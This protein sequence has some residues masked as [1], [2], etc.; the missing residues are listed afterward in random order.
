[1][2]SCCVV[3]LL[4]SGASGETSGC[5]TEPGG[6][7][8][9]HADVPL[10]DVASLLQ[11]V[12][13]PPQHASAAATLT[14]AAT[15]TRRCEYGAD[16]GAGDC[17]LGV[18]S[19]WTACSKPC[20][21]GTRS[22]SRT[23]LPADHDG[24]CGCLRE[25]ETCNVDPCPDVCVVGLWSEWT[26][27]SKTCGSGTRS[28]SREVLSV[29]EQAGECP[30]LDASETCSSNKC[31]EIIEE[32]F[33]VC[34]KVKDVSDK[35]KKLEGV[36]VTI[37]TL[38]PVKTDGNGKFCFRLSP[39]VVKL[40]AELQGYVTEEDVPREVVP[41][42]N[43]IDDIQMSTLL[44]EDQ[45]RIVLKWKGKPEDLDSWTQFGRGK[46]Q[47]KYK[48]RVEEKDCTLWW[49][50]QHIMKRGLESKHN[51]KHNGLVDEPLKCGSNGVTA[52]LD[53]DNEDITKYD[54]AE[55]TTLGG[56]DATTC[57]EDCKIHFCVYQYV[58]RENNG[59]NLLS[60]A[61]VE[62]YNGVS[63]KSKKVHTFEIEKQ[64]KGDG[65][66]TGRAWF[67]FS[68]DAKTKKVTPC[69]DAS[70]ECAKMECGQNNKR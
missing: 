66:V 47:L 22:R 14:Q 67:V 31:P 30:C 52:H 62:I 32:L 1:M 45:W 58:P 50:Y 70:S 21:S 26:A 38:D 44:G 20:G 25:A 63:H 51:G 61:T 11:R 18:W 5:V 36:M 17:K 2:R 64:G 24:K 8:T 39:G 12:I 15:G 60:K 49:K 9:C 34:G 23:A 6:P 59:E 28:R 68:F 29:K 43:V 3:A 41:G 65:I 56:V 42:A 10:G 35:S 55:T 54:Q 40:T 57:G 37:P 4:L 53:Q 13:A 16:T 69:N 48:D 27:C 33:D 19:G 46:M 7:R